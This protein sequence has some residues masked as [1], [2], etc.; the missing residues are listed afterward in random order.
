MTETSIK[1]NKALLNLNNK[2]LE[3][4]NDSGKM[5]TFLMSPLSKNTESEHVSQ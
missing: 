2:L 1:N 5:A 3:I 4:M